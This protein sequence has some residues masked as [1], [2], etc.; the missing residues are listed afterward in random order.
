MGGLCLGFL[1][2]LHLD[3]PLF[4]HHLLR[5]RFLFP[6]I[7]FA[8]VSKISWLDLYGSGSVFS[9]T[10]TCLPVGSP[11]PCSPDSRS[12]VLSVDIGSGSPLTCSSRSVWRCSSRSFPSPCTLQKADS[13]ICVLIGY[14]FAAWELLILSLAK[15]LNS[16]DSSC[17][18]WNDLG[19]SAWV[20]TSRVNS[21]YFVSMLP[22][23]ITPFF[24]PVV[25][26][27]MALQYKFD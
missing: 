24:P 22:I 23:Q 25:L 17:L 14:V 27:A 21:D 20:N 7:T 6:C 2:F 4:Q 18:F 26:L 10:W 1:V 15:V 19:F 13:P 9:I 8:P 3:V 5:R 16:I 12:F 11:A